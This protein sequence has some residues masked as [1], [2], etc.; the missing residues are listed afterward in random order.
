V[1]TL[2]Y[3]SAAFAGWLGFCDP[4]REIPMAAAPP[5]QNRAAAFIVIRSARPF[6]PQEAG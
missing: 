1:L 5:Y 4:L 3:Q 2:R 6:R